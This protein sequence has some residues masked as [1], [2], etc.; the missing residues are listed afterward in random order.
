[1]P[2]LNSDLFEKIRNHF[3]N[4]YK[5]IVDGDDNFENNIEYFFLNLNNIC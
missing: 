2:E 3:I 5:H 4:K 1:M